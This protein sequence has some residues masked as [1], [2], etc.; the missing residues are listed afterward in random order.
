MPS[1]ELTQRFIRIAP[2]AADLLLRHPWKLWFWADSIGLEG[3][4]DATE[5]TGDGRYAGY[6]YGLLK[7]WQ[8]RREYRSKFDYTA[9][10]VA[11]V[12]VY[13]QT[14][15][16][17]LLAFARA[18][19]DYLAGFRR[20]QG[21]AYM[22]YENAAIELPPE[23]P[24]DH[25]DFA[26]TA[27]QAR[28]V[29]NGGPCVFVDNM[30]FDGPFYARLY[31]VT[32]EDRYRQLAV[33]NLLGSIELLFDENANLFYHFWQERVR[34]PN[35]V[36]WGR[37]NGW[38]MLGILHTVAFLPESDTART[39]ALNVFRRQADALVKLQDAAT[40]DWH[41]V[42]D[43]PDSY[44]ETSIAAFV[45]DGFS[46]AIRHGW[47]S[48]D[49]LPTV[50]RALAAMLTHVEPNGKLAGVSYETFPSTRREHYR[51]M[52]RDA[53]VPWGQGPLLTAMRSY[54][55]LIDG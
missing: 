9:P 24:E 46:M 22:R 4:L 39:T 16:P 54:Q 48:R 20:T 3:L 5:L 2:G 47:L 52:P 50:E 13:E 34:R 11:L 15:D 25:P 53:V 44:L 18:H 8:A 7:A 14:G 29:T 41:T 32:G 45:V 27:E 43:D 30:H 42:L 10:G 37:G 35:G 36:L 19:A 38:A 21:G 40:G 1:E 28:H 55:K 6:V 26:R 51:Q 12:R 17:A 31:A 23:L 33:E 49:Y